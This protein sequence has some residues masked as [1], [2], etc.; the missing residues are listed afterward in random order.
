M[1]ALPEAP[2]VAL[3][4]GSLG[5]TMPLGHPDGELVVLDRIRHA[6]LSGR[7]ASSPPVSVVIA[8]CQALVRA[9]V[10]ALLERHEHLAV[11]GEAADGEEAL[12]V[13]RRI[14]P[15]VVLLDPD[16]PG[17]DF[18]EVT[19]RMLAESGVA[20]M[21]LTASDNDERII[22]ALRAGASGQVA[23]DTEP[24]ELARAVGLLAQGEALLSPTVA[25]RLIAEIASRPEPS[26]PSSELLEELTAREREVVAL[27]ALGLTND[28]IAERLVVS[29][30]TAKTHVSRA[31]VKLDA[32]DRAKLV[33]FAYETGLVAP[34]T[35][36]HAHAPA[37]S[38]AA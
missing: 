35:D 12:A 5:A 29:R 32:Q 6:V 16:L 22:A 30:A 34:R 21:L 23:R 25:R 24:T 14:D 33:V 20:V 7:E 3:S 36:A 19:R 11:V 2:E 10:R 31:M 27:V 13:V 26:A 8:D 37:P 38:L 4:N 15:D 9:G 1:N 18:V 17:V 28:E